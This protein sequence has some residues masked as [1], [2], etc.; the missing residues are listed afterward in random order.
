M[1]ETKKDYETKIKEIIGFVDSGKAALVGTLVNTKAF[2]QHIEELK[3]IVE[4]QVKKADEIIADKE[5]TLHNARLEAKEIIEE[6]KREVMSQDIAKQAEDYARDL[7]LS[8][9]E[10]VK[11]KLKKASDLRQ[12]MI[13]SNHKYLENLYD[14]M[15]KQLKEHQQILA[16]NREELRHYLHKKM[17]MMEKLPN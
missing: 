13:I 2:N 17:E 8:A 15:E 5:R 7:V 1:Q 4:E 10:E 9:Q 6:A 11:D 16:E 12:K 3:Q 14:E